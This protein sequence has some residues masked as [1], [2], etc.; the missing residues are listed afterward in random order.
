MGS[1]HF[2]GTQ[3]PFPPFGEIKPKRL[4]VSVFRFLRLQAAIFRTVPA[5]DHLIVINAALQNVPRFTTR[6][7]EL[8][9]TIRGNCAAKAWQRA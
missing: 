5:A 9:P 4:A 3:R 8:I 1:R 7:A 2:S 6:L